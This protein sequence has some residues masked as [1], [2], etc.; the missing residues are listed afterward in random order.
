MKIRPE[1]AADYA[2]LARLNILAFHERID[3]SHL[4][5]LVR[6]RRAY[7]PDLCLV[8]ELDGP[9]AGHIMFNPMRIRL[10][11]QTLDAVNLAPVAVL[12]GYQRQGIGRALIE[13]GHKVVRDK[14][15]G[16][17]LLLG[18]T[19]YYPK[20]GYVMGLFGMASVEVD[21]EAEGAPAD[22]LTVRTVTE[23]DLPA[24]MALWLHEE[25]GVDFSAEP[26]PTL[27]DWLSPNPAV[28]PRIYE[29]DG[30][31]VGYTRIDTRRPHAPLMFLSGDALSARQMIAWCA[32]QAGQRMLTL[33]LHPASASAAFFNGAKVD[34][35]NAAMAIPLTE[36]TPLHDFIGQV[37]S[38][39][40]LPGR[41]IWP[42]VFD[43]S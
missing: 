31:I 10:M 24:L 26:E 9:I 14:G 33:P 2:A 28:Q 34:P 18:H 29:R 6:Q 17:S 20:F 37:K 30:Q 40:R 38:G 43:V 23:A 22:S 12:P 25:G 4:V 36:D 3:E 1:T 16:V 41:L 13:A 7:D 19:D 5:S 39:Q 27:I 32:A 11:G 8:A 15:Y 21:S 42:S 35:W